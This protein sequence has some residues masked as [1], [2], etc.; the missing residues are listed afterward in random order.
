MTRNM[1][2]NKHFN[3]EPMNTQMLQKDRDIVNKKNSLDYLSS[4]RA[5]GMGNT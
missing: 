3:N 5:V 4:Y 2:E 1:A